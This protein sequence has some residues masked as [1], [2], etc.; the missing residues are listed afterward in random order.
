ML[1]FDEAVTS[2]ANALLGKAQLPAN[3]KFDVVIDPL[4]DGVTG[5]QTVTTRA[6]GARLTQIIKEGYPRYAVQPFS[7]A[8]VQQ[9]PLILIGTLTGVNGER[10][11]EGL[12]EAYRICLA[13]ADLKSGKLVSKGLAFAKTDGVDPSPLPYFR[14]APIWLDDAA[15]SGYVRTC[16]GTRAG[17][18]INPAY[19]D[20]IVTAAT[21]ADAIE[22]YDAGRYAD[23]LKLSETAPHGPGAQGL[24]RRRRSRPEQQAPGRQVPVPPRH[25]GDVG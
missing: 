24:R 22:S 13:L 3:T 8:T 7:A 6:M 23:A 16:Q 11:S 15:T 25:R 4:I 21:I 10:K 2:A 14:D 5:M 12:R 17:D 9:G 1:P 20:R 18:P 19:L